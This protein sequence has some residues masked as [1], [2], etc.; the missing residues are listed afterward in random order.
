MI[1]RGLRLGVLL[2]VSATL[3]VACSDSKEIDAMSSTGP[4]ASRL[5]PAEVPPV[6][7]NGVRY[8]QQ[9][10]KESTDGQVG[11][12]LAAYDTAGQPL[13][14]LKVYDNRRKPGLEGDV[15]DVFF[16][17]MSVEP[18]GGLRIVNERG[19]TFLVDVNTRTVTA[20]PKQPPAEDGGLF[21]PPPRRN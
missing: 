9:M 11:G 5:P 19:D 14:T 1:R 21:P 8:A 6:T 17:A 13:W 7:I 16:T 2:A 3:T 12:I 4:S 18:G 15:Q 10:G 20:V